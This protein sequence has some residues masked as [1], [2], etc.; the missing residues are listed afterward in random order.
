M[1]IT[2]YY[3]AGYK[4]DVY[5]PLPIF[6]GLS[7]EFN[8]NTNLD[9]LSCPA[10]QA[11][12]NN[13]F[14]IIGTIDYELTW[15]GKEYITSLYD[16]TFFDNMIMSRGEDSGLF[17][18]LDPNI[19]FFTDSKSLECELIPP[20]L[21]NCDVNNLRVI[22]GKYDIGKHLRKIE[23]AAQF[24]KPSTICFK[25]QD[26]VYYLKF[27]TDEKII[28]KRFYYSDVLSNIEAGYLSKRLF[29]K[30]VTPFDVMYN[31]NSIF[32]RRIL[33]EIKENLF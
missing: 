10:F 22:T 13:V 5:E 24:R 11:S 14:K 6:K 12:C 33:K 2:V 19:R 16:Q 8:L 4:A 21:N 15:T 28:F 32:K 9:F 31:H 29:T 18:Y 1:T 17:S 20:Y 25:A 27:Y 7:E 3:C 26:P 23:L 30:K